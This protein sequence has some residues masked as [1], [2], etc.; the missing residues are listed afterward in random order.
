ME[1]APIGANSALLSSQF[2]KDSLILIS[3]ERG[4]FYAHSQKT[5]S[6]KELVM[7]HLLLEVHVMLL[8]ECLQFGQHAICC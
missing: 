6:L 3:D 2:H 5:V 8:T 4:L 7:Q 1:Q